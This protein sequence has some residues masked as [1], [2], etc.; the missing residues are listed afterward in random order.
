[1]SEHPTCDHRDHDD[2]VP[3]VAQYEGLVPPAGPAFRYWTCPEHEPEGLP[4]LKRVDPGPGKR[5]E[6]Q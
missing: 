4:A 6:Q 1:M 2:E 3:A 5:R